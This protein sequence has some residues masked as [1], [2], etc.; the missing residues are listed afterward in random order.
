MQAILDPPML[1]HARG[2]A[3]AAKTTA[4]QS[5]APYH[6]PKRRTGPMNSRKVA[7][8]GIIRKL[9]SEF[10]E[11]PIQQAIAESPQEYQECSQVRVTRSVPRADESPGC[12]TVNVELVVPRNVLRDP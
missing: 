12:L 10:V 3:A 11:R 4:A 8:G 6:L 9:L 7:R 1:P 5:Q 2:D